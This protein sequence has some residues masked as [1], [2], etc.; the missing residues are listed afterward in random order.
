MELPAHL[1]LASAWREISTE[2]RRVVGEST[3]EIW[4]APLEVKSLQGSVLSLTAP[5]TTLSWVARR[6]TRVLVQLPPQRRA[7]QRAR[8][9]AGRAACCRLPCRETDSAGLRCRAR[10][11]R[12]QRFP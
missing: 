11:V 3:Y 2:L 8:L 1:E 7:P 12:L 9:P 5:P 6:F 4:L 10:Q